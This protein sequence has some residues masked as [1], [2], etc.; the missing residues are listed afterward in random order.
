MTAVPGPRPLVSVIVPNYNY[1]RTLRLCLTALRNQTY[2]PLEILVVD[3]RSTD[4]SVAVAESFG[5]TVLRPET[6]G[7]VS[8]ARNLGAGYATGQILFFLDSDVALAA[9]AIA[10]A[11]TVLDS[12][13]AIGAVC[14]NYDPEPLIRD[15]LV[16]EYRNFQQYYVLEAAVG[17]LTHFIHPAI[18]AIRADVFADIGP[19]NPRLRRTEGADYGQ[20]L[21][22]R[23]DVRLS[24]T[25]RGRH[26]NDHTLRVVLHKVFARSRIQFALF[27]R[28]RQVGQVAASS[29]ARASLATLL[30]VSTLP[31]PLLVGPLGAVLPAGLL[32]A[33]VRYDAPLYRAA[34]RYR[35]ASFGV[36]CVGVHLLVNLAIIGGVLAGLLLW[37]TS[38]RYRRMHDPAAEGRDAR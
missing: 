8:R 27:R 1:S 26:D 13:P 4:D 29:G 14:G 38:R 23:Y 5:V 17:R 11:V 6:N 18:F 35:G 22:A 28:E 9:D 15:S 3:D 34:I 12:D 10:N 19:F 31:A 21:G 36:F 32:A 16:E 20:R 7:G 33:A 30:A 37:S 2:T 25:V 24:P